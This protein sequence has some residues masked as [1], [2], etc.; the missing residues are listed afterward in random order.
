MLGGLAGWS[1]LEAI[2]PEARLV[3]WVTATFALLAGLFPAV[4]QALKF[5]VNI[6]DIARHAAEFKNLNDRFR[7][8]KNITALGPY[9]E[10]EPEFGELMDRLEQFPTSIERH[11]VVWFEQVPRKKEGS[12]PQLLK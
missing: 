1:V 8:A 5:D 9:E 11:S 10:F 6:E 7:Q 2:Q 3:A 4:Y 12:S